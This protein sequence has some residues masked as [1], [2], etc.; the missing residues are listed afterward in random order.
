MLNEK[1]QPDIINSE[2]AEVKKIVE[3]CDLSTPQSGISQ[4][5]QV[6]N[7]HLVTS[8]PS[9][10]PGGCC[11]VIHPFWHHSRNVQHTACAAEFRLKMQM[12]SDVDASPELFV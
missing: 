2:Q 3:D 9:V 7:S 5:V 12:R 10:Q 6:S 1:N 8:N 4:A 11:L